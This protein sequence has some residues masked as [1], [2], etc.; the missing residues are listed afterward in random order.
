MGSIDGYGKGDRA[1][2]LFAQ[3]HKHLEDWNAAC[4]ARTAACPLWRRFAWWAGWRAPMLRWHDREPIK[5][6][7]PA[8]DS[9]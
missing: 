5:H 3:M 9:E 7:R 6:Y 8:Q 2:P 1:H 4:R